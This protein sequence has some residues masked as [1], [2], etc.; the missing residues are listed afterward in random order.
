MGR[1]PNA[2]K[3]LFQ[4]PAATNCMKRIT[5][6]VYK[7]VGLHCRSSLATAPKVTANQTVKQW[8]KRVVPKTIEISCKRVTA[9]RHVSQQS[10]KVGPNNVSKNAKRTV[11]KTTTNCMRGEFTKTRKKNHQWPATVKVKKTG[12]LWSTA[13]LV[14]KVTHCW[15][16]CLIVKSK[17]KVTMLNRTLKVSMRWRI[18]LKIFITNVNGVK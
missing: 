11:T 13:S 12:K 3:Q 17:K 15:P 18:S 5:I 8:S 4:S 14:M 7:Q 6:V 10:S 1:Q 2:R 16:T 9:S